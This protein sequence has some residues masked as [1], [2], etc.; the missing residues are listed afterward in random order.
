MQG[1]IAIE[2]HWEYPEVDTTGTW[3][4]IDPDYFADLKARL[5][6][7]DRRL[8]EMDAVGI[9][10]AVLSLT[11]PGVQHI[12]DARKASDLARKMNDYA[13]NVLA[14]KNPA[15]L[16]TFACVPLQ[17]PES[18]A[19]E[20]KRACTELGC[21]GVLVNGFTNLGPDAAR[22]LDHHVNAPFW[23]QISELGVP[24]YLHPRMPLKS[25]CRSYEDYPGLAGSAWGFGV[26]TATHALR[27]MLSGLFDRH[28]D[29]N[30][31]LG[32]LGEGLAFSLPRVEHR[33]R[34][35]R[36]EAHGPH[37][38]TP[39]EYLREN[40][41]VTTS[42]TFRT[43]ALQHTLSELGSDRVLFSVDYPYESMREISEWFDNCPIS[44][45]DK[46]KLASGNAR[47]IL[48]L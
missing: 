31:I 47:R 6:D 33:L 37:R 21:L 5:I 14:R 10:I 42:G 23:Q 12:E 39:M 36:A 4:F 19:A 13:A 34:H 26:E 24:V 9:D 7:V 16:K 41:Y 45:A 25:Q 48:N 27:L 3:G 11:Q 35:Q 32:H 40:F 1:K 30:V 28:P 29:V 15:R 44:P 22:Y 20:A 18:A 43:Q 2:E 8:D 17:D 46:R 38:K